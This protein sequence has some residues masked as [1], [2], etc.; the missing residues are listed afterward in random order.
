MWAT[1]HTSPDDCASNVLKIMEW[2]GWVVH[3]QQNNFIPLALYVGRA[4]P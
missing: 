3:T 4:Q 2:T 1:T